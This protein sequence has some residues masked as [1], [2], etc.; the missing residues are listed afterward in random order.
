MQEN[1][2]QLVSESGDRGQ[3]DLLKSLPSRHTDGELSDHLPKLSGAIH[4]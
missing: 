1:F 2:I 4:R 3:A